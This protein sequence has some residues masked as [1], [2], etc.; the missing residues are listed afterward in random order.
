[1]ETGSLLRPH[2]TKEKEQKKRKKASK[3]QVNL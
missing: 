1:L 3:L 2:P